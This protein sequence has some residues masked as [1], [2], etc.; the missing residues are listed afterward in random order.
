MIAACWQSLTGVE[1]VTYNS[2]VWHPTHCTT[3]QCCHQGR[4]SNLWCHPLYLIPDNLFHHHQQRWP[5]F[6]PITLHCLSS[7]LVNTAANYD[8]FIQMSPPRWCHL[9]VP[10][11]PPSDATATMPPTLLLLTTPAHNTDKPA[12]PATPAGTQIL[13]DRQ[14]GRQR[15]RQTDRQAGRQRDRQTGRQVDRET[16]RQT[17]TRQITNHHLHHGRQLWLKDV[18]ATSQRPSWDLTT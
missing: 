14:A 8:T 6:S 3:R 5:S 15:D 1:C 7:V 2:Q 4:C 18:F 13:K 16:E 9:S 12:T 17:I 10:L 11:H